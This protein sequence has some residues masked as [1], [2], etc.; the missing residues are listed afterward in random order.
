M[1]LA[2]EKYN[3]DDYLREYDD[4]KNKING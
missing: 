1:I 2:S 4:F 3:E